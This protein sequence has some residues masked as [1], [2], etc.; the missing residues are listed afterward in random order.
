MLIALFL[1]VSIALL[2]GLIN[3]LQIIIHMNM[4]AVITPPNV[5]LFYTYVITIVNMKLAP[6]DIIFEEWFNIQRK[7]SIA[8]SP[9]FASTGYETKTFTAN[10]STII[11]G[12]LLLIAIVFVT[13]ALKVISGRIKM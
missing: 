1:S 4:F 13:L 11:M 12:A 7:N 3:T 5:Q 2:W 10:A 6:I 9:E 8:T